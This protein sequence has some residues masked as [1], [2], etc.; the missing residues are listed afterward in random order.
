[1]LY[2]LLRALAGV[3]LRWYYRRVDVEG[4]ER[5]PRQ[6]PLLIVVNHP[7]ALVDALLV[8]WALPRRVVLTAKSTLFENRALASLLSWVGVVPLVRRRDVSTASASNAIDPRRNARAFGALRATLRRK[9]AVVIFPEGLSHDNPSLAPLKTGAARI[10][11][12]ARDDAGVRDLQILPIGLVFERKETPRSRVLVQVGEPISLE[13][14]KTTGESAV[15][16]L[17][18]EIDTRLRHVTL[19][20][21]SADDAARAAALSALLA[22]LLRGE[23]NSVGESHAL[24]V[25][26]SLARRI[27]RARLAL[28]RTDDDRIRARVDSLVHSLALLEERLRR[29]NVALDD[30]HLSVAPRYATRFVIRETAILAVAGPVAIWGAINHFL[31]F[32][33]ARALARRA[34]QSASDPAMRTI[35]A[36]AALVLAFYAA[37]SALIGLFAGGLAA[38]LYVASL[39]LAA[40]TTFLLA[41]RRRRAMQR[42]RTYL[43]FRR[44]PKLHAQLQAELQRLQTEA[45]E[46]EELL[47]GAPSQAAAV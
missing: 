8:G 24:S 40:D 37:Q 7:N 36:G 11:L 25:E 9:G 16:E 3:A 29:H 31:P 19:N 1:M 10:A 20:Y 47:L 38:L 32:Y 39:P 14:W 30:I 2:A 21:D 5:I 22:V 18:E 44:R 45:G 33:A 27:E 34:V 41:E 28:T 46:V 23:P 15:A 26:V 43:R 42:A 35:V 4:L 17:T 6:A 13:K 12:E